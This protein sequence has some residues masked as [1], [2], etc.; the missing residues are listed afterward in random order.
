M[1]PEKHNDIIKRKSMNGFPQFKAADVH[2]FFCTSQHGSSSVF[3]SHRSG[4]QDEVIGGKLV[5]I[6]LYPGRDFSPS[7]TGR[8]CHSKRRWKNMEK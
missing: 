3:T 5:I 7:P 6:N 1:M 8:V 4:D 2:D